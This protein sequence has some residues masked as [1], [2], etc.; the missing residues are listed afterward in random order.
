MLDRI[1][2]GCSKCLCKDP[3]RE[4]LVNSVNFVGRGARNIVRSVGSYTVLEQQSIA[5]KSGNSQDLII[6]QAPLPSEVGVFLGDT[7]L[8]K[9]S[10]VHPELAH[11][12]E[13]DKQN[14]T[15]TKSDRSMLLAKLSGSRPG[16]CAI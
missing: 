11:G 13:L 5:T 15:L 10:A 2:D 7:S 14:A 12:D 6:S 9:V 16:R 1:G 8:G 3:C 4:L